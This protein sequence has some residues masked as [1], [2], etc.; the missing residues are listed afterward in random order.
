MS[1]ENRFLTDLLTQK[2]I[3]KVMEDWGMSTIEAMS[4]VYNSQ[5][6]EKI[7]DLSTGLYYQSAAY[8]YELLKHE[9]QTGRLAEI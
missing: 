1:S 5:T 9:L 2:L 8:N 7:L 3:L 4:A 6:Y